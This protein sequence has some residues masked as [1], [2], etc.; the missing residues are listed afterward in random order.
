M[1]VPATLPPLGGTVTVSV[2]LDLRLAPT[3]SPSC[4]ATHTHE[5]SVART[6][7]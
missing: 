3:S 5:G 1:T 6:A 4:S 2:P 7:P